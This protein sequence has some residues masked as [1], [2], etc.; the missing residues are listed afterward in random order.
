MT[1]KELRPGVRIAILALALL[2]GVLGCIFAWSFGWS[3]I[4]LSG[5]LLAIIGIY[6]AREP[7]G[8][9][10]FTGEISPGT[11][12]SDGLRRYRLGV[13]AARCHLAPGVYMMSPVNSTIPWL[14]DTGRTGRVHD[15]IELIRDADRDYVR[16]LEFQ[17][18]GG[19]QFHEGW[20]NNPVPPKSAEPSRFTASQMAEAGVLDVEEAYQVAARICKEQEA[21]GLGHNQSGMFTCSGDA[22]EVLTTQARKFYNYVQWENGLHGVVNVYYSGLKSAKPVC[23]NGCGAAL[24]EDM[25]HGTEAHARPSEPYM[26]RQASA[27]PF[28]VTEDGSA[29]CSVHRWD[30]PRPECETCMTALQVRLKDMKIVVHGQG[31]T[32]CCEHPEPVEG[33]KSSQPCGWHAPRVGAVI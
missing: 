14:T 29:R 9:L 22:V 23:C 19:N 30:N 26:P 20:S 12:F 28:K 15:G 13:P 32:G 2:T 21:A 25:K 18:L 33:C 7:Q 16:D 3:V 1:G 27:P 6:P 24:S 11:E 5:L 4:P 10:W 31:C 17:Y 8:E